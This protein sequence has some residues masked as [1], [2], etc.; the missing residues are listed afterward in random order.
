MLVLAI[1]TSLLIT[2]IDRFD[3]SKILVDYNRQYQSD[4]TNCSFRVD[5]DW[6]FHERSQIANTTCSAVSLN[7]KSC[8]FSL[9]CTLRV[10][11]IGK[12]WFWY[13]LHNVQYECLYANRFIEENIDIIPRENPSYSTSL[14]HFPVDNFKL[15]NT[16]NWTKATR[17][18][19]SEQTP[20]HRRPRYSNRNLCDLSNRNENIFAIFCLRPCDILMNCSTNILLPA[21][22][23]NLIVHDF[24]NWLC[25]VGNF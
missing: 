2:M 6:S 4:Q 25:S 17:I 11:K 9:A 8:S 3:W 18:F 22:S 13:E 21:S 5:Q 19:K 15:K 16:L 10:A 24:T 14:K 20:L 12:L 7:Y 23:L 1:K